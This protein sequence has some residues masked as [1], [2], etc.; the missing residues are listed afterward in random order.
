[1]LDRQRFLGKTKYHSKCIIRGS[2]QG[3]GIMQVTKQKAKEPQDLSMS[4]FSTHSHYK[5]ESK[6]DTKKVPK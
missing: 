5:W 4:Y 6:M 1:M 2:P 3:K